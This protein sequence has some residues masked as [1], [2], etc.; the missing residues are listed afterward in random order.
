MNKL[1]MNK[2][3]LIIL[4]GSIVV[5]LLVCII[6]FTFVKKDDSNTV[7]TVGDV[8]VKL[9]QNDVKDGIVKLML[10][11][12]IDTKT[13]IKNVGRKDVYVWL[14]VLVP[15]KLD[16]D[17]KV[18]YN[19]RLVH[20]N[21]MGAFLN[22]FQSN[23][24]YHSAAEK[25]YPGEFKYPVS[26]DDTWINNNDVVDTEVIDG[27]TYNVYILKYV[28]ILKP[29]KITTPGLSTVFLDTK[30][31]YNEQTKKWFKV[32]N[33]VESE[34]DYDF[35]KGVNVIVRAH[36]VEADEFESFDEAFDSY[37]KQKV[38]E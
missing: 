5:L 19:N 31:S 3:N 22:G 24:V 33:N 21:L 1:L 11:D 9:I 2:K 7:F 38:T 12:K 4:V 25:A 37:Y 30:I 14:S 34:I 17:Q 10:D 20:W 28:G 13:Q 32:I 8:D 18:N 26:E 6:I 36:A 15:T 27:I 16:G 35:N 29:K 23:A